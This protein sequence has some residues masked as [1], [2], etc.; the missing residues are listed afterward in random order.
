MSF[1]YFT[2]LI[3]D[4]IVEL[5]KRMDK[6]E[7]NK[8][9]DDHIGT[10]TLWEI[11]NLWV[12]SRFY[13]LNFTKKDKFSNQWNAVWSFKTEKV[14]EV[15]ELYNFHDVKF[16]N[17]DYREVMATEQPKTFFYLDPPYANTVVKY[18]QKFS[19]EEFKEF[20]KN[21]KSDW[22]V[23]YN[24]ELGFGDIVMDKNKKNQYSANYKKGAKPKSDRRELLI[25]KPSSSGIV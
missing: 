24:E 12:N 11:F 17:K 2:K 22:L 3:P 8:M 23:S 6:T 20:V 25:R 13:Y 1:H 10:Y 4:K 15:S 19:I 18:G 9:R 16:F 7:F 14:W 5:I 21:L